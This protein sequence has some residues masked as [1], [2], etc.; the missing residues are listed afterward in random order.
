ML[1]QSA[2]LPQNSIAWQKQVIEFTSPSLCDAIVL[3][4]A[5]NE[6]TSS[7]CPVFGVLWLDSFSI[8]EMKS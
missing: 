5:R 4:L 6:C 3:K 8:E 7:P 2:S 1:A